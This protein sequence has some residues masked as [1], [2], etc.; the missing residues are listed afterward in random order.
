[1]VQYITSNI[2]HFTRLNSSLLGTF[3]KAKGKFRVIVFSIMSIIINYN[4]LYTL[5][6]THKSVKSVWITATL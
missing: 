5:R 1:M 4:K 2:R 3:G 6:Y